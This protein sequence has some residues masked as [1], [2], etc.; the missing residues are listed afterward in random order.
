[1]DRPGWNESAG[2]FVLHM[3]TGHLACVGNRTTDL[4]IEHLPDVILKASMQGRDQLRRKIHH[5][6]VDDQNC[7]CGGVGQGLLKR[8]ARCPF[9]HAVG[10][11]GAEALD[12]GSFLVKRD[13]AWARTRQ[14]SWRVESGR[15]IRLEVPCADTDRP[16]WRTQTPHLRPQP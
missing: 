8:G 1:M 2:R 16:R 11:N 14:L 9:G 15:E 5:S 6:L 10:Q 4:R 13:A 3:R 7:W 12:H